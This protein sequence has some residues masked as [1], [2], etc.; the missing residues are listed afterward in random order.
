M[1]EETKQA[2]GTIKTLVKMLD[3]RLRRIENI[4]IQAD[5]PEGG[6]Y[7]AARCIAGKGCRKGVKP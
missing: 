3:E 5:V 7:V 6:G 1:D 2:I 4:E